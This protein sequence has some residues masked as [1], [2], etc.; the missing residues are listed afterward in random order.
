MANARLCPRQ[1]VLPTEPSIASS[2]ILEGVLN[3][4][5][6]LIEIGTPKLATSSRSEPTLQRDV[7]PN[8]TASSS[9]SLENR[10]CPSNDTGNVVA[11]TSTLT[12]NLQP[13][14]PASTVVVASSPTPL[15]N[16]TENVQSLVPA[17]TVAS[18]ASVEDVAQTL[19]GMQY[20]GEHYSGEQSHPQSP[21]KQ[22]PVKQQPTAKASPAGDGDDDDDNTHESPSNS[23]GSLDGGGTSASEGGAARC[24]LGAE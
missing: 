16:D 7:A 2:S 17:S 22:S 5:S 24:R 13:L 10:D 21:V 19:V 20:S 15:E 23:V 8:H 11:N 1:L 12:E 18:S 4:V 9:T 6:N 3:G 14:V